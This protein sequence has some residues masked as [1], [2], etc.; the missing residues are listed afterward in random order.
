MTYTVKDFID[1][2]TESEMR[3]AV[4]QVSYDFKQKGEEAFDWDLPMAI[5]SQMTETQ[6]KWFDDM[7]KNIKEAELKRAHIAFQG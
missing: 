4:A 7:L 5:R 1:I 6:L 2:Q 3:L